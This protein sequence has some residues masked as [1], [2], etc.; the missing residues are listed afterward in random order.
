[1]AYNFT[2]IPCLKKKTKRI[3]LGQIIK[4]LNKEPEISSHLNLFA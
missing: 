2:F 4:D 1:M 3:T